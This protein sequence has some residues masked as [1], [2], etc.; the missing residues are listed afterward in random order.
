M[1]DGSVYNNGTAVSRTFKGLKPDTGY[2]YAVSAFNAGGSS[3]Y[4]S[5]ITIRT[6]KPVPE[7]PPEVDAIAAIDSVIVRWKPV[8]Y[9]ES[10]DI[11]FDSNNYHVTE[12]GTIISAKHPA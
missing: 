5:Q 7:T 12:N 3:G 9:A 11:L 2:T 10:Y 6:R 8:E 1:F 4:S